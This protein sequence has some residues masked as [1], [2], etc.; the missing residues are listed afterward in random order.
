MRDSPKQPLHTR[1]SLSISSRLYVCAL[2]LCQAVRETGLVTKGYDSKGPSRLET[3]RFEISCNNSH[4]SERKQPARRQP[5][6]H[7]EPGAVCF[8][9]HLIS[10]SQ[11]PCEAGTVIIIPIFQKRRRAEGVKCPD[12]GHQEM[13]RLNKNGT[14]NSHVPGPKWNTW[15][16]H[17][18]MGLPMQI[19]KGKAENGEGTLARVWDLCRDCSPF[20]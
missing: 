15:M 2:V 12:L 19:S 3:D 11:R 16:K 17:Q 9:L 7:Q 6:Q 4:R 10:C 18:D 14:I 1:P 5:P 8:L 20:N 13:L